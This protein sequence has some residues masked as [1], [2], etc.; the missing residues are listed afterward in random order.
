VNQAASR[1]PFFNS[2]IVEAWL[3]GGVPGRAL[4]LD[5]GAKMKPPLVAWA[6]ERMD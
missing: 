3:L 1:S 6:F 4:P 5:R 2:T